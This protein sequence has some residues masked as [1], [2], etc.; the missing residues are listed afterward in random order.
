MS[1]RPWYRQP[2][3]FIALAALVV[4]ISAV[5]VG[6][7]EAALQRAHDR[8]EVWPHLEVGTFLAERG[9]TVV[10]TNSGLGPAIVKSIAVTIDG[11]PVKDWA[12]A[13]QTLLGAPAANFVVTTVF[14]TAV[15][16]GDHVQILGLG[17]AQ[18][19]SPFWKSIGRVA[20]TICYA[21][22]FDQF[23]AIDARL[24]GRN[25]WRAVDHCPPQ[26]ADDDL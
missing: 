10:L 12:A 22:V 3:L 15:R 14:D 6:L 26:R 2:D 24:G 13:L 16:P 8:A 7:Y 11:K 20:V 4:S 23:W 9:A 19:P 1:D 5:A 25:V 21:S 17:Q 18:M